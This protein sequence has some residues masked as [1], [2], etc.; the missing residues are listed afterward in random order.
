MAKSGETVFSAVAMNN[1]VLCK[2][3]AHNIC[4]LVMSQFQLGIAS[5]F[6]G[7]ED[8]TKEAQPVVQV[9]DPITTVKP[10]AAPAVEV[11]VAAGPICRVCA[12]A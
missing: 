10:T 2:I 7:E 8:K 9:V 3:L 6:W 4:C 11:E 5:A 1:E 12:G